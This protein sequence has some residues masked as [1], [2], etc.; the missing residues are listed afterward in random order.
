MF[1]GPFAYPGAITPH[2]WES[3]FPRVDG[4]RITETVPIP[5]GASRRR[6]KAPAAVWIDRRA[7]AEIR[8]PAPF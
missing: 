5:C 3:Q 4:S 1:L 2:R 7:S 6:F 8:R